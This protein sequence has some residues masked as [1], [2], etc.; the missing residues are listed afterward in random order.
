MIRKAGHGATSN[1]QVGRQPSDQGRSAWHR[2]N[3]IDGRVHGIEELDA[4]VLASS[5]VPATGEAVFG[6]RLVIKPN[7]RIHRRRSSASARRR[8]SA[9]ELPADSSARARRARRSIS[10]AQAASTSAGRSAAASSRLAR[11]S[12][13]T[14]A[15]SSRGSVRAS[16]S[17]SCARDD[18]RPSYTRQPN[19]RLHPTPRTAGIVTARGAVRPRSSARG[20]LEGAMSSS[21]EAHLHYRGNID[22]WRS[23]IRRSRRRVRCRFPPKYARGLASVPARC[24]SGMRR[25]T[26]SSSGRQP[27]IRPKTCIGCCFRR[28][29]DGEPSER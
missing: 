22:R 19:T 6:V 3:L 7:A 20:R 11:S 27:A 4:Q 8:T 28:R 5:L 10:V 17:N 29:R 23:H 18:M 21:R 14:S 16:R 1:S 25:A 24:S 13:A 9:Q 2:H 12:A 26:G 15:R